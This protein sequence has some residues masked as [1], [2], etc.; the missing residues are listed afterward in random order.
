GGAV[1]SWARA[2]GGSALRAADSLVDAA[3][4]RARH[5]IEPAR[6]FDER[7]DRLFEK[8]TAT[9]SLMT[10][11]DSRF[12]SWR[13]GPASPHADAAVRVCRDDDGELWGYVVYR[14]LRGRRGVVYDL[15]V[16]PWAPPT[17]G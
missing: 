12:L 2:V 6:G 11:R 13:Y 15:Q 14:L 1:P 9:A 3:G 10:A 16:S 5:V 7:F 17:V 4:L 8:L